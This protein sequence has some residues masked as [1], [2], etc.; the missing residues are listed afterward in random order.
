MS[1]S[2]I[3]PKDCT[4]GCNTRIYWNTAVNKYWEVLAQITPTLLS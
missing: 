4:Y 1:Q 2:N 3:Y